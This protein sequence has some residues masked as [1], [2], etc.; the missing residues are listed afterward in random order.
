[1]GSAFVA[2]AKMAEIAPGAVVRFDVNGTSVSIANV[3]GTCYAFDDVCTHRACSLSDGGFEDAAITCP[4]H[5]G[6]FDVTTGAVLHPPATE[7][8]NTY[9]IRV[10]DESIAVQV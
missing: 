10:Q 3:A 1:M 2:V 4:C 8:V 5:G 9:P 7:P 6:Q